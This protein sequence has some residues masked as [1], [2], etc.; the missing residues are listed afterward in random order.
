[1]APQLRFVCKVTPS[2]WFA[3]VAWLWD[4]L[5]F[6]R[7]ARVLGAHD[8]AFARR[9]AY[10][11]E[12]WLSTYMVWMRRDELTAGAPPKTLTYRERTG[13]HTTSL[14]L[15]RTVASGAKWPQKFAVNRSLEPNSWIH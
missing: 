3:P 7:A 9:D 8:A 6:L 14:Q 5:A 1:M 10:I 11:A 4:M 12:Y 13:G 2:G 15:L